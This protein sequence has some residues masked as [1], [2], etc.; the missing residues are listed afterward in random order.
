M[1]N[2]YKNINSLPKQAQEEFFL[3]LVDA[4]SGVNKIEAAQLLRDLLSDQEASMIARRL[5]IAM[6][7]ESGSSYEDIN[8]VIKVSHGTIAKIQ[9]WLQT[10]GDGFRKVIPKLQKADSANSRSSS[11]L[12][13]KRIKKSYPIYFWP[14]ILLEEVVSTANAK[15]RQRLKMVLKE[16]KDKTPLTKQ[17][18]N[19]LNKNS[20]TT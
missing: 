12:N 1:P 17:L 18:Q 13:W 10:Y 3:L 9:L 16:L 5:K 19:L 8:K 20:S 14:Q 2:K 7:L 15:E 4:L 6:L 11:S